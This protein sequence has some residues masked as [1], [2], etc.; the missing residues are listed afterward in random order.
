MDNN[1]RPTSVRLSKEVYEKVKKEA[2]K[3]K[4]SITKQIEY[5]ITDYYN[6]KER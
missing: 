6:F 4:R 2:E 5:I 3:D 1:I